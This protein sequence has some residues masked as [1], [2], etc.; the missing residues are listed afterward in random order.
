ML[1]ALNS[2]CAVEEEPDAGEVADSEVSD[3]DEDEDD[4]DDGD[5]QPKLPTSDSKKRSRSRRRR[6]RSRRENEADFEDDSKSASP[7][8]SGQ[9]MF[10]PSNEKEAPIV[11]KR[12]TI[13]GTVPHESDTRANV[14]VGSLSLSFFTESSMYVWVC[15]PCPRYIV[16]HVY[17]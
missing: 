10:V 4:E 7:L 1:C 9:P 15:R 16:L 12:S 5:V 2:H 8:M 6:R 3:I 13:N 17:I 11:K 14:S